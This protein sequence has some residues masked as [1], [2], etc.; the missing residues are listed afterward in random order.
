V[1]GVGSAQDGAMHRGGGGGPRFDRWDPTTVPGGMGSKRFKPFQ[2]FK[3]FKNIQKF[4]DFD[5]PKF[6]LLELQKFEIKYGLEDIEKMN[7]FLHKNFFRARRDL[8]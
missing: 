8:E 3:W 4:P 2:K 1:E 5:R 6:D 7:N